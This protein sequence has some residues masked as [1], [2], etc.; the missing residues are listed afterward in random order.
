[1]KLFVFVVFFCSFVFLTW[2]VTVTVGAPVNQEA[3]GRQMIYNKITE[4]RSVNKCERNGT[5]IYIHV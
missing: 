2:A 5:G 1:M 4:A 3:P